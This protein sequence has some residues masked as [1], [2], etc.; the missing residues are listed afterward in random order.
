LHRGLPSRL[1]GSHAVASCRGFAQRSA[2]LFP[3]AIVSIPVG[4]FARANHAEREMN[5]VLK[6]RSAAIAQNAP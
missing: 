4:A 5:I 1:R 3:K 6:S 2:E